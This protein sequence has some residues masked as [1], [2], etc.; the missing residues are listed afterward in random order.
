[1]SNHPHSPHRPLIPPADFST[2]GDPRC[3]LAL[4]LDVSESMGESVS[5]RRPAIDQLND[6]LLEL[7]RALGSD[8]LARRRVEPAVITFGGTVKVQ[9]GFVPVANWYPPRLTA[10][11]STP[12]G[13]AIHTGIGMV[14]QRRREVAADGLA[15][16]KPWMFLITDGSPTDDWVEAAQRA[17]DAEERG[18]FVLFAVAADGA[19]HSVLSRITR[20]PVLSLP[21]NRWSDLFLWLSDSLQSVSS[22]R[23]GRQVAIEPWM[24]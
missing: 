8:D 21:D 13:A 16:F 23:P 5:G 10:G 20:R 15:S 22:S 12:M 7:K 19:D 11:G 3:P 1:M 14:R 17:R 9:S 18:D 24:V 6:G 4:L 2:T